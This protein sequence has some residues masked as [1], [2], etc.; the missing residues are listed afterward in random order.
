M[1]IVA[2]AQMTSS[3]DKTRNIDVAEGLIETA[4][5]QGARLVGLP[6][7]FN[8]MGPDAEKSAAAEALDGPTLTRLAK[9]AKARGIHLLAG[10]ILEAGAPGG[11]LYNTSVLLGPTGERL[12]VYRKIH[13]FDVA[14]KDG[15]TYRESDAVAPGKDV[16]VAKTEVATLGL[17]VCYDLR[18]PELYRRLSRQGAEVLF[19][20]AAFTYLTGQDHW[21]VLLRARAIENLTFVIAPAQVGYHSEK[22]RT[23]G[24]AMIIDPWGRVLAQA[25]DG[26]GVEVADLDLAYQARRRQELPALQHRVL[27]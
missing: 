18:F 13:L 6:E 3:A 19:V 12:A 20:P 26:E 22:K 24:H 25:E 17:S 5:A 27:D 8:F 9:L 4:C 21:E 14:I 1:P 10:T 11:R 2:A 15:A 7:T 23:W 16:V